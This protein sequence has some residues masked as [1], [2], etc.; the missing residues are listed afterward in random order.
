MHNGHSKCLFPSLYAYTAHMNQIPE[1]LMH[2]NDVEIKI[3]PLKT[4]MRRDLLCR[5]HSDSSIHTAIM[6]EVSYDLITVQKY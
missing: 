5:S 2:H 4:S 6:A 3:K 1:C